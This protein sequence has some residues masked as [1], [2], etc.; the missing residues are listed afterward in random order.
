MVGL[1]GRGAFP[2]APAALGFF[3]FAPCCMSITHGQGLIHIVAERD[4][5]TVYPAPSS[6]VST[7]RTP[8]GWVILWVLW[9]QGTFG[10]GLRIAGFSDV[11]R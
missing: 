10:F 11:G 7:T 6:R 3:S 9:D 4:R 2:R 8:G 5:P 1:P